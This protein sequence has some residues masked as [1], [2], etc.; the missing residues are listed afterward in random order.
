MGG[1]PVEGKRE[2]EGGDVD[3][4]PRSAPPACFKFAQEKSR[5]VR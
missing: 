1:P 5:T 2:D 3:G 4:N